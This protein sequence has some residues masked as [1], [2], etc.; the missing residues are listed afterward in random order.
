MTSARPPATAPHAH[1]GKP[2]RAGG[3]LGVNGGVTIL[4]FCTSVPTRTADFCPLSVRGFCA[5][6]ADGVIAWL[7]VIGLD[8]V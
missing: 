7:P 2:V 3:V 8:G 5:T 1:F 4:G 6:L